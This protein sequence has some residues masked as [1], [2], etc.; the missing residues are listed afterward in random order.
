MKGMAQR[1]PLKNENIQKEDPP[2]SRFDTFIPRKAYAVCVDSDGCA[3]DT[4]N[5]K[6]FR[7][8]GPCIIDEWNL[9][10]WRKEILDH[11][12]VLNL[13]SRTR[14]INRFDGLARELRNINDNYPPIDG[15]EVFE[16]WAAKAP[17]LSNKAVEAMKHVHPVFAKALSWSQAVNRGIEELRDDEKLPFENVKEALAE[18]HELAD[19]VI[20]SSANEEAVLKEWEMYGLLDHVDLVCSQTLGSKAF[21]ISKVLEKGYEK[22]HVLMCGDAPGDDK[23]ASTNGVLYYPI[24][25]NH[26]GESWAR[27]RSEAFAKFMDGSFAGS[28]Q[29]ALRDA[30]Y[31]NLK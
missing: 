18:V 13:F 6:H 12:N 11:W 19:V 21:C 24:L 15:V 7:C 2:M 16:E 9:E 3:M 1:L 30:F 20:V 8:F 22:D 25:V 10:P 4:M 28:Y 31:E 14:G 29:E 5:I 26:E 17:E 27:F 23:A